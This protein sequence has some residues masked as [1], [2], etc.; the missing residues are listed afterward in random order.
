M[1]LVLLLF[2]NYNY[3]KVKPS[4][5]LPTIVELRQYLLKKIKLSITKRYSND[6]IFDKSYHI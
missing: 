4:N 1:Y 6:R 2:I 3:F 5:E